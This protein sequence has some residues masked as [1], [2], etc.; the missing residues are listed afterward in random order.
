M[1]PSS[2]MGL[3]AGLVTALLCC[4]PAL[5]ASG[6]P[7][8]GVL[9]EP[10]SA[11]RVNDWTLSTAALDA[12][13]RVVREHKPGVTPSQVVTAAAEDRVLGGYARRRYDEAKLFA[14][15]RVRF[16]PQ[17]SVEASLA[18]TLQAAFRE[19]LAKAMGPAEGYIVKRHPLTRERLVA[20]L[21]RGGK[22]RLD[23]RLPAAR[24]AKLKDLPLIDGRVGAQSYRITLYDVWERQDVQGR[25]AL[26]RFDAGFAMQQARQL[27]RD[28]FTLGWAAQNSGLGVAGVEQLRQLVADRNRR[29]ALARLL[30]S[31]EDTHYSSPEVERLRRN[32]EAGAIR[33]Y[34]DSHKAE[35]TR[36][37]KVAMRSMRFVDEAQARAVADQLSKGARFE[38]VMRRRGVARWVDSDAA[39]RSWIAQLAFAQPPGPASPPIRE[40]EAGTAAPGWFIVK[41]DKRVTG[42]HPPDSETVRFA[43]S[44]AIARQR[45]ASNFAGLRARLLSE[46]R[47][48]VNPAALGVRTAPKLLESGL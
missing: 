34:Y 7:I 30:G 9:S 18:T 25:D 3:M 6:V 43:A 47:I 10:R 21:D 45:A 23:D 29:N 14:G 40:P 15:E 31:G 33:K 46:A 24:A 41:V 8:D 16:S 12:L 48:E 17:A 39:R 4:A 36:T 42:L 13:L 1:K 32:V 27:A 5:A 37:D 19:P 20:L 38:D 26:Y 2:A 35:F 28:R 22:L 44:E 11:L